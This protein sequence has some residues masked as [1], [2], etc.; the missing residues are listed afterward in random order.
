MN[1]QVEQLLAKLQVVVPDGDV[2]MN[3]SLIQAPYYAPD[4]SYAS[5][6]VQGTHYGTLKSITL[7]RGLG[8]AVQPQT[9]SANSCIP[10]RVIE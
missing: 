4:N 8:R 6:A 2:L 10:P 1:T 9:L 7:L 5:F 3:F